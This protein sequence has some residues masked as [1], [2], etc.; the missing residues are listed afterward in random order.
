[1]NL[2]AHLLL[3]E[4]LPTAVSA[5]NLLADYMR[6]CGARPLDDDFRAGLRLHQAIDLFTDAHD[7]VLAS[8]RLVSPSRRRVSGIVVDIAFDYCLSR[9]WSDHSGIPIPLESFVATRLRAIRTYVDAADTPLR[10]IVAAAV[11]G[12]W[13][14]SYG[15]AEGLRRTFRR[16][17]SRTKAG[18]F[19]DGAEEE[20]IGNEDRLLDHFRAFFP[21]L[22]M[23][24]AAYTRSL[25][26][27]PR[28]PAGGSR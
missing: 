21:Q 20:I 28:T 10:G 22:A 25:R 3:A 27:P 12:D 23:N 14:L 17:A 9:H 11:A 2:L 1:M 26:K 5:G 7:L 8:R 19:L 4:G 24:T 13:L 16:V 6:R 18:V 15:T